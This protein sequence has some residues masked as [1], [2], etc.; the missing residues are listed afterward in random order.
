[1]IS[2]QA[3]RERGESPEVCGNYYYLNLILPVKEGELG[4]CE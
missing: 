4:Q 3:A 2:S 1:M